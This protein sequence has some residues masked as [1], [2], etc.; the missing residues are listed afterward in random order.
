M[1][2]AEVGVPGIGVGVELDEGEGTVHGGCGP[3]LGEGDRVVAAEH[4][5]DD[6]RPV[7]GL[8]AFRYPAVAL[9]YVAGDD[10]HVAVVYDRKVVED[11]DI[12][13]RVVAPEEVRGRPY[14]L[15]AEAGAGAEGGAGV[16]GGADDRD[17]AILQ[18]LDVWQAHEGAHA[19][20]ARR[21]KRVDRFVAGQETPFSPFRTT[22]RRPRRVTSLGA[23]TGGGAGTPRGSRRR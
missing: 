22:S 10:G 3:Q 8:E 20:E 2:L 5:G 23:R 4:Y 18:V 14:A 7:Y 1:L 6:P 13:R 19:R 15:G 12:L 21:H 16:E 9:L 17:V 11:R